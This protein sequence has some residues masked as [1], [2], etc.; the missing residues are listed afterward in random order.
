[1]YSKRI[2][3][4]NIVSLIS[5]SDRIHVFLQI[6]TAT[7]DSKNI[8]NQWLKTSLD[9]KSTLPLKFLQELSLSS[10]SCSG[11]VPHYSN[12]CYYNTFLICLSVSTFSYF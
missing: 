12:L 9:P 11:L 4:K 3:G 10:Q 7:F 2:A 8:L 6:H 1:M 5:M